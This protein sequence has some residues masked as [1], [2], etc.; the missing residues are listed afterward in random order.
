MFSP[1]DAITHINAL[2]AHNGRMYFGGEFLIS[3]FLEYGNSMGVIDGPDNV[4]PLA[5]MNGP[6]NDLD[7]HGMD[8]LVAGG[9]FSTN[10]FAPLPYVATADLATAIPVHRL[11]STELQVWPNPALDAITVDAGVPLTAAAL[12]EVVDA[13]GAI[14]AR[15]SGGGTRTDIPVRALPAGLYTLRITD[16]GTIRMVTFARK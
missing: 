8:Q 10:A 13:R 3:N 5:D 12:I 4:A 7:L 15:T 6:V 14:V 11:P 1:L 16:N 2:F 9:G